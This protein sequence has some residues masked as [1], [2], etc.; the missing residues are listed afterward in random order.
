LI[1]AGTD[2]HASLVEVL[3]QW[4]DVGEPEPEFAEALERIGAADREPGDP[5]GS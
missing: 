1:P 2:H 3:R 5:W 4:R